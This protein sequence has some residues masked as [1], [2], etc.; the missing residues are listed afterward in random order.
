MKPFTITWSKPRRGLS[1]SAGQYRGRGHPHRLVGRREVAASKPSATATILLKMPWTRGRTFFRV[2]GEVGL[3]VVLVGYHH[4]PTTA[5]P[6][7]R[8]SGTGRAR[9][10]RGGRP[11]QRQSSSVRPSVLFSTPSGTR[12]L[13]MSWKERRQSQVVQLDSGQAEAPA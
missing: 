12:D 6:A 9:P 10:A 5:A 1:R 8:G 13:P 7:T 3:H 2:P 11:S 4:R